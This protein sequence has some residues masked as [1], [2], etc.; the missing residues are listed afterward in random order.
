[1][2]SAV[3]ITGVYLFCLDDFGRLSLAVF[4]DF[5]RFKSPFEVLGL[6]TSATLGLTNPLFTSLAIF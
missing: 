6:K 3:L 2:S 1:V 5:N 4:G